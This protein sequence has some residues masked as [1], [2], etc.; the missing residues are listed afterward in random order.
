MKLSTRHRVMAAATAANITV[1]AVVR[2]SAT[3]S[4]VFLALLA[5]K[6][7]F[8]VVLYALRSNWRSTAAGRAVMRLIACIALISTHGSLTVLTEA[9]YPGR[10]FV[11]P[12]LLAGVALAVMDLLVT[13]VA[14]QR[15]GGGDGDRS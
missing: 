7:W 5:I 9:S 15:N 6:S 8:F 10:P 13:L 11:R 14:I 12:V 4:A 1:A 3:I 2:D